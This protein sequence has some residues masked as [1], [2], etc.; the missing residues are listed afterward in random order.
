VTSIEALSPVFGAHPQGQC[1]CTTVQGQR[2]LQQLGARLAGGRSLVGLYVVESAE[3]DYQP[4]PAQ[5]GRI[6]A[7]VRM[8][9]M[10]Y[11]RTV[12]NFPSGCVEYRGG[13]IVDRWPVGWP[14]ETIFFSPHGGPVLRDAVALALRTHDFA[15]F[16]GQFLQGP[17]DLRRM[18]ALRDRLMIEVR[19][20]IAHDPNAQIQPF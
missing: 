6:V 15:S 10:P 11:G 4:D 18:P 2:K 7:L 13:Q 20:V 1:F 3:V 9:Q 14:S 8:L 17:I 16:A 5:R 12:A 19:N